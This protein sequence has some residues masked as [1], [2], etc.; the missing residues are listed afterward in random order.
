VGFFKDL[1]A[2]IALSVMVSCSTLT[3]ADVGNLVVDLP[4]HNSTKYINNETLPAGYYTAAYATLDHPFV[5][6]VFSDTGSP[7]SKLISLFTQDEY[8]HV[9]LAFDENLDTLVSYNGGNGL[10]KPGLNPEL[11]SQFNQKPDASFAVYKLPAGRD[12]K[13]SI[14]RQV[15]RI[16]VEGSSYNMTGLLTK[17]T[18]QPNIMFCSQFVYSVLDDV[19]L[20]YFKKKHAEEVRPMDF[21]QMND[22]NT[23]DFMYKR[24]VYDALISSPQ[25][26]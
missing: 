4:R 16:N 15:V 10:Y 2:L 12:Q 22:L 3:V 19:D 18:K 24:P 25:N 20:A 8:N 9:S 21:I 26:Y 6:L 14:L 23:L 11:V 7:A 13:E 17:K 5:Y 1:A